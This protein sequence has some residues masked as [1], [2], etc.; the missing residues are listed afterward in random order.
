MNALKDS[1]LDLALLSHE[2]PDFP[3]TV[4]PTVTST[5]DFLKQQSPQLQL[6]V[7]E[8]QTAGRG[9]LGKQWSS[10]AEVNLYFSLLWPSQKKTT[11][12]NGLSLVVALSIVTVLEEKL[13]INKYLKVKW[14]ND[15][16]WQEKKLAGILVE[17]NAEQAQQQ[18]IIIGVGLNVNMLQLP[19]TP[20]PWTSLAF[21][22][23]KTIN[24]NPLLIALVK[25]LLVDLAVFEKKGLPH[26][27]PIWFAWDYLLNTKITLQIAD[28]KITGIAKGINEQGY[29]LLQD[30]TSNI[31]AYAS[32]SISL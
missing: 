1:A 3:I 25:Q 14:P 4:L 6:C 7:A 29:L 16:Y 24:R 2:L 30:E 10:P 9:R 28:K 13:G 12:L 20:K 27:L 15:I 19:D 21:I 5:N 23:N 26:F 18:N 32:G 17:L 8:Q 11:A 22:L 31:Q